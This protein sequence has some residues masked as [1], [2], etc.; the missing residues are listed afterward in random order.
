MNS[1]TVDWLVQEVQDLL[2]VSSVGLYE[3]MWMLNTPDQQLTIDERKAMARRALE[4][5]LSEPGVEL[6]WMRWPEWEKRGEVTLDAL[7]PDAWN[8]PGEN[9]MYLAVDRTG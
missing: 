1:E 7:P 8:D 4:R 9:G 3:F 5:L 6:T 2:D